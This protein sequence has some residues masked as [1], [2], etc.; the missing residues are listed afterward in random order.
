[1]TILHPTNDSHRISLLRTALESHLR[2]QTAGRTYLAEATADA[3]DSQATQ[4]EATVQTIAQAQA[5]HQQAL[6][7]TAAAVEV[8]QGQVRHTWNTVRW[9]VR[10]QGVSPAVLPYYHLRARRIPRLQNRAAWLEMADRLVQGDQAAVEAGYASAIDP[11]AL[12]AARDALQAAL[13]DLNETKQQLHS[14]RQ[15]GRA[16]RRSSDRLIRHL[17]GDLRHALRDQSATDQ[18]QIMRTY[19]VHF[20]R[21]FTQPVDE[22]AQPASVSR[23]VAPRHQAEVAGWQLQPDPVPVEG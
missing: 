12:P 16:V 1:M 22:Q 3:L 8:L 5:A 20:Q 10:W 13:D 11:V 6:A 17:V 7:Q 23:S 21:T 15:T 2:G 9:Q 18:Q 19:G 14:A 4:L